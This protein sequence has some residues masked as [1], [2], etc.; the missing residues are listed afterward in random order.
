[1][2]HI[3]LVAL[4]V[5]L[6]ISCGEKDKSSFIKRDYYR[7]GSLASEVSYSK[8]SIKNGPA[9]SFYRNGQLAEQGNFRNGKRDGPYSTYYKDGILKERGNFLLDDP[10]GNFYYY[11]PN[12]RL[13]LYNAQDYQGEVFYVLKFDST[14]KKIKEDG[15]IISPTISSPTYK[16]QY[17]LGDSMVLEF[18]IA[19]PPG[20]KATVKASQY[21]IGRDGVRHMAGAFKE[22]PI[23]K[24]LATYRC[25][26][27]EPGNYDI[28]CA[29]ELLD[30][31]SKVKLYDTSHTGFLIR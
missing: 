3:K 15:M 28:V 8:D 21:L 16:K 31:F 20:Y 26:F 18:C 30:T 14:G 23:I 25:K 1:M 9:K 17:T 2:K 27:S 19:E 24:S 6:C 4:L 5:I 10:L 13:R 7:D 12:G 22:V 11:Y 29:A